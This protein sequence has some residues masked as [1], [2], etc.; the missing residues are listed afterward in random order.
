M[1][2]FEF[3]KIAGAV[4]S[5]LLLIVGTKTLIE[6]NSGHQAAAPGYTLP[7][8]ETAKAEAG[9]AAAATAKEGEGGAGAPADYASKVL[10]ILPKASA[11]NGKAVFSK[12][13]SCHVVEKGKASTVGPNLWGVVNRP[14]GSYE[15]F[16]YSE[17]MKAKGGNWTF[18]DLGAFL[19]SPKEFV[20]GTKMVFNGLPTP[21][22]E[23][24]VIAYLATLA[25]TP[26]PLPK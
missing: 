18:E 12:C 7:A 10:A 2:S 9:G 26:V 13:K 21:A 24:D 11:E 25:D 8:A 16:K 14:K 1:D 15:G 19:H 5:A 17:G 6:T 20:A 23:A 4:L 3:T 22:D